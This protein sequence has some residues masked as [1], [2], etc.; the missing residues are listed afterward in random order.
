MKHSPATHENKLLVMGYR[1]IVGID[2]VG[3]GAWAGPVVAAAVVYDPATARQVK[4]ADSKL[5]TPSV[6]ERIFDQ[7]IARCRYAIGRVDNAVID[8]IGILPATRQA[9]LEALGQLTGADYVLVDAVRLPIAIPYEH[10]YGGDRRH[11]SIAAA[12]IIAKVARDRLM[13]T[14]YHYQY[15]EYNFAAHKGYGTA[16][17]RA[18]I[19]RVG[20]CPLHRR[21]YAPIRRALTVSAVV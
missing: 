19:E 4:V 14:E 21:S 10:P 17:H 5:L 9:M 11:W 18:A 15:N 16:R 7:L 3:R 13:A 6:R 2:E 12:S 1:T 8:R 20:I